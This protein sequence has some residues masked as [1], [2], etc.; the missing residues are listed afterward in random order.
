VPCRLQNTA[1]RFPDA[2]IIADFGLLENGGCVFLIKILRGDEILPSSPRIVY[3]NLPMCAKV[4]VQTASFTR[5]KLGSDF[6]FSRA[7]PID[8]AAGA[9][10]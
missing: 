10:V 6:I 2:L 4:C 9:I 8:A 5:S 1:D 3:A 7:E